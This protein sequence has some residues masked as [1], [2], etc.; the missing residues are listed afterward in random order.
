MGEVRQFPSG[1]K[2]G[3]E[4][5]DEWEIHCPECDGLAHVPYGDQEHWA[6]VIGLRCI[7]CGFFQWF[8]EP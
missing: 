4:I 3:G 7:H 2:T 1:V 6:R 5:G 8:P